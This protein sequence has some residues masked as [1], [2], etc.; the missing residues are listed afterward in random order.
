M[1]QLINVDRME[2]TVALF[3]NFDENIKIAR[4]GGTIAG[5]TRKAIEESSGRPV[6]TSQNA[7]E[8]SAVVTNLIEGIAEDA[9]DEE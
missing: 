5:D 8:L 6:I 4:E 7:A 9:A 1:E 3:G 2:Q